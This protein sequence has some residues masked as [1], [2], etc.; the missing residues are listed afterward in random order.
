[1]VVLAH[2]N[3][4]PHTIARYSIDLA[5]GFNRFY[6]DHAILVD[7]VQVKQARVAL[8]K[9]VKITLENALNLICLEAPEKM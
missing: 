1:M 2:K 4:E 3:Y 8:V 5:Q 6:H 7:D 9:A